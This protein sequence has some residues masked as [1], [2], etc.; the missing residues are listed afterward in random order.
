M[1][2]L[3]INIPCTSIYELLLTLSD[4]ICLGPI[5]LTDLGVEFLTRKTPMPETS[6]TCV[7]MCEVC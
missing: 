2:L 1:I 4:G 3:C 6:P 5:I 7:V